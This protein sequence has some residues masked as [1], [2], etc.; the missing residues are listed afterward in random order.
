MVRLTTSAEVRGRS[1]AAKCVSH[2]P[3]RLQRQQPK[4]K[5]NGRVNCA[6]P[7]EPRP[8]AN[9]DSLQMAHHDVLVAGIGLFLAFVGLQSSE[10]LGVVA[11]DNTSLV[12]LGGCP[13]GYRVRSYSSP[14]AF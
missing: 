4:Q 7:A 1:V 14:V 13:P 12:N 2:H 11:F 5:K 10:G 9:L 6:L 8:I 3:A